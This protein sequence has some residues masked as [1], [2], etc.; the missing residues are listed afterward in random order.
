MNYLIRAIKKRFSPELT[1]HLAAR[2]GE[3]ESGIAKAL[4]AIV[5]VVLQGFINKV[6]SGEG[7]LVHNLLQHSQQKPGG[8]PKT[9][10]EMLGIMGR[11]QEAGIGMDPADCL[12]IIL[13]GGG[14]A[15]LTESI[16]ASV[17][18]RSASI[19]TLLGIVAVVVPVLLGQHVE[20]YQLTAVGTEALLINLKGAVRAMMPPELPGLLAGAGVGRV[21]GVASE[22]AFRSLGPQRMGHWVAAYMAAVNLPWRCALAFLM[23]FALSLGYIQAQPVPQKT[24]VKLNGQ[25]LA[26]NAV[27]TMICYEIEALR[28]R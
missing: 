22:P 11:V 16:G 13:F 5:P 2:L 14:G 12:L 20:R 10:T 1:G 6:E 25:V 26:P 9:V 27:T 17:G 8:S 24:L 7:Q 19:D 23:G 4:S 28:P 18:V 21:Q 15:P 3:S